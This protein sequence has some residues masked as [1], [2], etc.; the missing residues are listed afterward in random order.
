ML[1]FAWNEIGEGSALIPN[2]VDGYTYLNVIRRVFGAPGQPPG[3]EP[4]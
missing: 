2:K 1:I 3:P 4:C